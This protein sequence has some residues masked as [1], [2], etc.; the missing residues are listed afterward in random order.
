MRYPGWTDLQ[1]EYSMQPDFKWFK[2][3]KEGDI[4]IIHGTLRALVAVFNGPSMC[5]NYRDFKGSRL[6][7]TTF[8]ESLDLLNLPYRKAAIQRWNQSHPYQTQP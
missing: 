2:Q 4:F 3:L 5:L 8:L 6:N 7:P 1:N